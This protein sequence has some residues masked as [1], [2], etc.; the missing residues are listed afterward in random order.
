MLFFLKMERLFD[1]LVKMHSRGRP[2]V[3]IVLVLCCAV[4]CSRV[5]LHKGYK[6]MCMKGGSSKLCFDVI[7]TVTDHRAGGK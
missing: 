4:L 3:M 2:F 1:S 7:S 5:S 6:N